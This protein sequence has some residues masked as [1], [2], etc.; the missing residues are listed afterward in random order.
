[1]I[2]GF[3]KGREVPTNTRM[4]GPSPLTPCQS[5]TAS[6]RNY[7]GSSPSARTLVSVGQSSSV[8]DEF[9][10][11][12]RLL[13]FAPVIVQMKHAIL[14]QASNSETSFREALP[15]SR[16][17]NY[18]WVQLCCNQSR[19]ST[20]GLA[21]YFRRFASKHILD[22]VIQALTS[23]HARHSLTHADYADSRST[24]PM[25]KSRIILYHSNRN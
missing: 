10:F 13:G 21:V 2:T 25:G 12:I 22:S 16:H 17:P 19:R 8:A 24:A 9:E 14:P 11:I 20:R 7:T 18:L 6:R 4:N 3:K 15:S 1:V 5:D 23:D